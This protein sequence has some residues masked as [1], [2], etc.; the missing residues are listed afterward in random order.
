MNAAKRQRGSRHCLT[1]HSRVCVKFPEFLQVKPGKDGQDDFKRQI[2]KI[3]NLPDEVE[4]CVSFDCK[5]VRPPPQAPAYVG[6][7]WVPVVGV[8]AKVCPSASS[9]S[10]PWPLPTP[11]RAPGPTCRC[12]AMYDADLTLTTRA[13]SLDSLPT[14]L[15]PPHPDNR[16]PGTGERLKLHGME[17]YSAA[18]HCASVAAGERLAKQSKHEAAPAAATASSPAATHGQGGPAGHG[19]RNTTAEGAGARP[20]QQQ[21]QEVAAEAGVATTPGG[22]ERRKMS[23]GL[24]SLFK[25]IGARAA[26]PN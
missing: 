7:L 1:R 9:A 26:A 5:W 2:R 8:V 6:S 20:M 22:G 11:R 21:H 13:P 25:G 17:S 24:L 10:R 16:A 18:M 19:H 12:N 15:T 14:Y 4:L 3:F 23:A